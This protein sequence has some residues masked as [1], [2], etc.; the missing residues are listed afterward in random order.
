MDIEQVKRDIES[1]I[2]NFVEV[3]HPAWADFRLVLTHVVHD[4]RTATM[5][6]LVSDPYF[7]LKNRARYGMGNKE[8]V[9]Y[10]Y[11]PAEWPHELFACQFRS[12]QSRL[13]ISC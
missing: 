13:F 12:C 2:V 11:D 1:W 9:I 6:S 8:V 10:A 5:C 7:D 3:P 4:S